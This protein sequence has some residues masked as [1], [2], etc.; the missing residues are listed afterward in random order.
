MGCEKTDW[1]G[2]SDSDTLGL[3]D[4]NVFFATGSVTLDR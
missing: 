3:R 2:A 4:G 1:L